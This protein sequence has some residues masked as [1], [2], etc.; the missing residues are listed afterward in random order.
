MSTGDSQLRHRHD[1]AAKEVA[2]AK[3]APQRESPTRVSDYREYL[4]PVALRDHV[5]CFW[6]Q[7]IQPSQATYAH[8][9]L[10]DAC[11]DL[12]FFQ[13]QPPAVI[14]PWT[15]SFVAQLAPGTRITGVRF[16]PGRAAAILRLPASE[17]LNQQAGIRE[18]WSAAARSP[19]AGI[20]ELPTFRSSRMALEAAL[21]RHVFNVKP[22][23]ATVAAAIQRIARRPNARIEELSELAGISSRQMQ[24]RFSAAVGYGPKMFQSVLRFQRLLYLASNGF[25]RLSLAD[26]AGRAG[27]ADQSHMNRE[28]RRFAAK[29]PSELLASAG[30]TL[31]LADFLALRD[32]EA[33][34]FAR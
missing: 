12:V 7:S 15:E 19:F 9:V 28:V 24:R 23:D 4:P 5:L 6:T 25:G 22:A 2:A 18:I 11:V 1:V 10:P 16:H 20:G 31:K 14:G 33:V 3:H 26:L 27:Y 17:L 30:C 8:R 21:L 13:G 34:D 29:S 32:D